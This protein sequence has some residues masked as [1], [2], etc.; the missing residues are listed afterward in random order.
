MSDTSHYDVVIIG[1]AV[2]GATMMNILAD[3]GLK[4]LVID[5]ETGVMEIPRAAHVDDEIMRYFQSF[6]ML[7]PLK[8]SY[9]NRGRYDFFDKNERLIVSFP[10]SIELD[11]GYFSGYYFHQPDFENFLR[12]RATGNGVTLLEHHEAFDVDQDR[13]Q[14]T[15]KF[16]NRAAP[17]EEQVATAKY[18][19]G[20]DGSSSFVR[21]HLGITMERL[22]EH[23]SHIIID[24]TLKE[25]AKVPEE[26]GTAVWA[27]IKPEGT[28]IYVHM[29]KKIHRL[30]FDVPEDADR[31][32]FTSDENIFRLI[33]PWVAREDVARI[34]RANIYSYYSLIADRWRDGR[35]LIA[36]DAAHLNPPF[37]G[38]GACAAIRDSFNLGWKLVRVLKGSSPEHLL[39]SYQTERRPHASEL[40]QRAGKIGEMFKAIQHMSDEQLA[41]FTPTMHTLDRPYLGAGVHIG[42]VPPAGALS[43]QPRLAD[44]TLL[45]E[46]I[47]TNFAV[48][49][50][51]DIIAGIHGDSRKI[52]ETLGAAVIADSSDSV[53]AALARV[54]GRVMVIRPDR[55]LLGVAS[56]SADLDRIVAASA[57]LLLDRVNS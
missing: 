25:G 16:R 20:C 41:S 3:A 31:D 22:A 2:A 53:E 37:L 21:K 7:K 6:G 8:D 15:V 1:A 27:R 39:D 17:G 49:G 24:F 12:D 44:G 4:V 35:I 11:Q 38:Q 33:A 29:P 30:E 5:K 9:Y 50:D 28:T 56:T 57:D 13:D 52:L 47:G 51:P 36:G 46:K 26:F 32:A 10:E 34:Y 45:D 14:V 55:Y 54:G 43:P 18:L 19:I 42:T 40:V 48:V 23:S